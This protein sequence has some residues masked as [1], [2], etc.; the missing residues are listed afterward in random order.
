LPLCGFCSLP[1]VFTVGELRPQLPRLHGLTFVHED[2]PDYPSCD[3]AHDAAGGWYNGCVRAYAHGPGDQHQQQ[4]DE[5][6]PL[7]IISPPALGKS[8]KY[9]LFPRREGLQ[10]ICERNLLIEL[11]VADC[12]RRL[13]CENGNCFLI[14]LRE[15]VR[16]AA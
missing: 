13:A 10:E 1:A 14:A 9:L 6:G 11:R 15:E 8:R 4:D 12:D 16:G 5:P 3:G 2:A 7:R